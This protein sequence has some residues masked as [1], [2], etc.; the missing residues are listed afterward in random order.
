MEGDNFDCDV[1]FL[2]PERERLPSETWQS[3]SGRATCTMKL[4]EASNSLEVDSFVDI[5][6]I[7]SAQ[8]KDTTASN[9]EKDFENN[10]DSNSL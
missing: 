8:H 7:E 1:D 9:P 4:T 2:Y 10:I 3:S 5:L 6:A